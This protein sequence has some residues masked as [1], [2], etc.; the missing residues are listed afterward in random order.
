[1]DA[2]IVALHELADA[3]D[4]IVMAVGE[5]D[6]R[7]AHAEALG[8]GVDLGHFPGRIHHGRGVRGVVV[9]QVDE[10]LHGPQF[11]GMDA[12]GGRLWA[13]ELLPSQ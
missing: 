10:V 6:V 1:V 3:V 8:Q 11:Q 2:R 13:W 7:D 12:V 4:V 9:D 5:Q